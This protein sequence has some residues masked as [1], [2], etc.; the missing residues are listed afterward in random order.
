MP[1]HQCSAG[2]LSKNGE[3]RE[4]KTNAE[5]HL[6]SKRSIGCFKAEH[7]SMHV[8]FSMRKVWGQARGE[9]ERR[10]ENSLG[11]LL[12]LLP[13]SNV[14]CKMCL[15]KFHTGV[16]GRIK[17]GSKDKI[18]KSYLLEIKDYKFNL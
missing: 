5:E 9:L 7:L 16:R 12:M 15:V 17:A 18:Y 3:G 6:F 1:F 10:W 8:S 11:W 14:D 4:E 13:W 2:V